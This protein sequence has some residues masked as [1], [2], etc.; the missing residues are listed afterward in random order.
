MVIN[1]F[2]DFKDIEDWESLTP[3]INGSKQKL[4]GLVYVGEDSPDHKL[5][6]TIGDR[7]LQGAPGAVIGFAK[8]YLGS[9]VFANGERQ[10][11]DDG[12]LAL[13]AIRDM[14]STSQFLDYP[15]PGTPPPGL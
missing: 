13:V 10:K 14:V 12:E 7:E 2:A 5:L 8:A 4:S 6:I 15:A 1:N 3:T 9:Y 11:L